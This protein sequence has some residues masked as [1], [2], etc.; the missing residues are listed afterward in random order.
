MVFNYSSK[1]IISLKTVVTRFYILATAVIENQIC[2][3]LAKTL[4]NAEVKICGRILNESVEA[5][6]HSYYIK[7]RTFL[8]GGNFSRLIKF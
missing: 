8:T 1:I 7:W 5:T 3:Q 4:L 2:F 6:V